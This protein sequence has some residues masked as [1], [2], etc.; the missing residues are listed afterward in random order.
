MRGFGKAIGMTAALGMALFAAPGSASAAG[1]RGGGGGAP[2]H[3]A[4][5]GGWHGGGA[6]PSY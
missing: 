6:A 2:A 1:W 4:S 3:A 5:A